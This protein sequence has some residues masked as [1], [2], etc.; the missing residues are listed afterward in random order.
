MRHMRTTQHGVSLVEVLVTL[1]V[2]GVGLVSIAKLQPTVI[3]AGSVARARAVAVQLAEQK[4]EDLRTFST[5]SSTGSSA[6]QAIGTNEGGQLN[7]GNV[8]VPGI[9]AAFI[10]NWQVTNWYF[11]LNNNQPAQ[12]TTTS[13]V[14]QPNWPDYKIVKVTVTWTD[15]NDV[16]QGVQLATI[17]TSAEPTQSGRVVEQ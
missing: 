8:S 1:V 17:I 9:N 15:Q 14:V 5:L 2:L 13:P 10:R 4:L 3:E 16:A 12:S 11:P 6:F 7:A